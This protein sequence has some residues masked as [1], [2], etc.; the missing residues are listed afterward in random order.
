MKHPLNVNGRILVFDIIKLFAIYLVIWGH[1]I[2]HL[3]NY[4]FDPW[5]NPLYRWISSFHM[6]LFMMIS[7]FFSARIGLS[8]KEYALK[9]F[10][11]LVLPALTFGVVFVISWHFATGGG[12]LAQYVKC[13][14]F[15]KSAFICSILYFIAEKCENKVLGY[16][17]TLFISLF[18]TSYSVNWM[19]PSFLMGVTL[20]R[21]KEWLMNHSLRIFVVTGIIFAAMFSIW[22]MGMAKDAVLKWFSYFLS[23]SAGSLS[24]G[25]YCFFFKVVM[26][27]AGGLAVVSLFLA[28]S[29]KMTVNRF[30]VLMGKWGTMTLGI[31]LC[32]ALVLEHWMMTTIDL[33]GM[34]YYMFNY[35][36]SPLISI[37]V[38]VVCV[39][40]TELLK[41]G[42]WLSF[43]FLGVPMKK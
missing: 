5:D 12:V 13:Y 24:R 34:E 1:C 29:R 7:G 15:L 37:G 38:L 31:Y 30:G 33:S 40:L 26:G 25:L 2:Q 9:K 43:I 3:Q 22:D 16:V 36:V 6:P 19:Y 10:R 14:W 21:H 32:Q 18:V 39:F 23:D 41:S 42:R 17:L 27:I 28:L 11:Q 20:C 4:L 8:F 35:L